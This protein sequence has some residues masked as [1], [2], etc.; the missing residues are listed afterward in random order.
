[1]RREQVYTRQGDYW[2][3]K[4]KQKYSAFFKLI[5][6]TWNTWIR[7]LSLKGRFIWTH[8]TRST[9]K[10]VGQLNKK[11]KSSKY[12]ITMYF[13][14]LSLLK[15]SPQRTLKPLKT[16]YICYHI[17]LISCTQPYVGWCFSEGQK[18]AALQLFSYW[19]T[20]STTTAYRLLPFERSPQMLKFWGTYL[21]QNTV[22]TRNFFKQLLWGK[23]S[24]HLLQ[25]KES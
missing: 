3:K 1:M 23:S 20:G 14:I 11:K 21:K 4:K 25:L 10:L 24:K 7:S 17:S 8:S 13:W 18:T 22:V 5:L 12:I 2:L 15:R 9:E 19:H 16:D 6:V